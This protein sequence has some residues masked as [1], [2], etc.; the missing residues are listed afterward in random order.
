MIKNKLGPGMNAN[1]LKLFNILI[2]EAL[3]IVGTDYGLVMDYV[4]DKIEAGG[5]ST[6]LKMNAKQKTNYFRMHINQIVEA[7][8]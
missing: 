7:N 6:A 1:D 5:Y 2:E 3:T 4:A 8:M